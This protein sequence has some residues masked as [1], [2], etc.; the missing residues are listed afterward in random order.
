M[1]RNYPTGSYRCRSG[2]VTSPSR[3]DSE[4]SRTTEDSQPSRD[5]KRRLLLRFERYECCPWRLLPR[6]EY[7]PWKTTVYHYYYFREWRTN[8]TFEKLNVLLRERLRICLGTKNPQPS[9]GIT[10]YSQSAK[11]TTGV[12]GEQRG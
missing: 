1:K 10:N 3:P 2:S 11:K 12:G 6:D 9:A 5:T 8:A 4:V 7:P